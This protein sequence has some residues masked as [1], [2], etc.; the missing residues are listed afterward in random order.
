MSALYGCQA[1][2]E[3]FLAKELGSGT[4]TAP[5]WI[6][7]PESARESCFAHFAFFDPEERTGTSVKSQAA[8][9]ADFFLRSAREERFDAPWPFVVESAGAAGLS[10][11]ARVIGEE[12]LA[13]IK[14]RV[15]RVAKLAAPGRPGPGPARGLFLYFPD[16]ERV[17]ASRE[18]TFGGQRRMAD[19]PRA[20]S[21]SYL[22]AE[23]AYAVL[24]REPAA[25][26][27]VADLGAAPGGWSYSAARR[28]ARV[29]AVDNGPLK[30]GAVDA[31]IEPRAEDAFKFAPAAPVD[32]LFCDMVEDPER[33]VALVRRWLRDALCARFVVNLKFARKDPLAL[34]RLVDAEIRPLCARLRARHLYH[35]REELTI[36]GERRGAL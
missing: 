20:P 14:A 22:K 10:R 32:W 7:G 8:A 6:L 24:G 30:A 33:V 3:T 17:Y 12:A 31:N 27:T 23:E 19:D 13:S 9:V 35:D 15:S 11:R 25:G 2:F 4:K 26:E 1:G 28:G 18:A 34:L 21:R 16:F 29:T 5:G 36:V